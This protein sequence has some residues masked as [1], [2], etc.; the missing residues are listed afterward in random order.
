M[1][2]KTFKLFADKMG[3][4]E[5]ADYIGTEG[6]IFYDPTTTSLRMSDGETAGGL[7]LSGGS[8]GNF[9]ISGSTLGTESES[10]GWG[11][12]WMYL[13]PG[14]ESY[15][16]VQ[17]P[18]VDNQNSG[19][20]LTIYNNRN[21]NSEIQFLTSAGSTY[22]F[23]QNLT[24]PGN[25]Y[26]LG[27]ILI[28]N[29]A[30]GTSADINLY[31]ADNININGR[32]QDP[33]NAREGGDINI[34]GGS[35][36]TAD[37]FDGGGSGGDISMYSGIGGNASADFSA[38]GGGFIT[39]GCR[40]GGTANSAASLNAGAGSQLHLYA[41]AGGNNDGDPLRGAAGGRVLIEGGN[42]TR[43]G[44]AGNVEIHAGV[45]S[46]GATG[47]ITLGEGLQLNYKED[48]ASLVFTPVTL[49]ALGLPSA[50]GAG[51]RAFINDSNVVA[52]GNFGTVAVSGNTYVV[53]VYSDGSNWRVG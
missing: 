6:E 25:I 7:A 8:L 44:V 13:D 17:I 38:G 24:I 5:A 49:S 4:R 47:L 30:S 20:P 48:I 26:G 19:S 3:G 51:A 39:I 10:G 29:S 27:T 52:A 34:D 32:D 23:G 21:A 16:G 15:S 14:G 42:A 43:V 46:A 33:G 2:N 41:G 18:S 9:K 35:G 40:S 28:D 37:E 12:Y 31:S 50:A 45:D 1:A 11:A 22:T 36:S 53:P